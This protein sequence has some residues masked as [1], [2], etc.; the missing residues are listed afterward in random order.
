MIF[1][2]SD[3]AVYRYLGKRFEMAFGLGVILF[4]TIIEN[5]LSSTVVNILFI[6][7]N[8]PISS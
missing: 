5:I 7:L 3:T 8:A 1:Q 2:R 4:V 6:V